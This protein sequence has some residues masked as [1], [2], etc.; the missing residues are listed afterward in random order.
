[1]CSYSPDPARSRGLTW[2]THVYTY[3]EHRQARRW[4]VRRGEKAIIDVKL[5]NQ[6][7][8]RYVTLRYATHTFVSPSKYRSHQSAFATSHKSPSASQLRN[9]STMTHIDISPHHQ[10]SIKLRTN[11][12]LAPKNRSDQIRSR[13]SGVMHPPPA[14]I[15]HMLMYAVHRRRCRRLVGRGK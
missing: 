2:Q 11:K 3:R 7:A 6:Q 1:M 9:P 8:L 13:P 5:N 10:R 14:I 12:D 15:A 4:T